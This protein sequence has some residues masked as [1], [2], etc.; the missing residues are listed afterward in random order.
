MTSPSNSPTK[1]PSKNPSKLDLF[2]SVQLDELTQPLRGGPDELL[3][4]YSVRLR[5]ITVQRLKQAL[6]HL[7]TQEQD[8]VDAVLSQALDA[9]PEAKL[10]LPA[11]KQ[12]QLLKKTQAKRR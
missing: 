2:G 7:G 10:P 1:T 3:V 11:A 8:F 5:F 9:L 12:A 6:H 4:G